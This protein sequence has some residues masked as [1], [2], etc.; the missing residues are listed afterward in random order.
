MERF[1]LSVALRLML[2][3]DKFGSQAGHILIHW[4]LTQR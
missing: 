4:R 1:E 2:R 3:G